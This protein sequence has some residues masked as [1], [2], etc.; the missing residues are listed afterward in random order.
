MYFPQSQEA[1]NP[2]YK[3]STLRR[4]RRELSGRTSPL[5]ILDDDISERHWLMGFCRTTK[6]YLGNNK[7]ARP[8]SATRMHGLSART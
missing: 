6:L 4:R 8:G 5:A 2:G 7:H 3:P 1:S